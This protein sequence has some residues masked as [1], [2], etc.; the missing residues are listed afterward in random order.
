MEIA[1][2]FIVYVSNMYGKRFYSAEEALGEDKELLEESSDSIESTTDDESVSQSEIDSDVETD[3]CGRKNKSTSCIRV[4]AKRKYPVGGSKGKSCRTRGGR[5]QSLMVNSAVPRF[6]SPCLSPIDSTSNISTEVD[7]ST[8]A[9]SA[10]V[11]SLSPTPALGERG[12][13]SSSLMVDDISSP[14]N[15]LSSNSQNIPDP[16]QKAP[17]SF[18]H[19][20]HSNVKTRNYGKVMGTQYNWSSDAPTIHNFPFTEKPGLKVEV[21]TNLIDFLKL[22]L[23]DELFFEIQESTNEYADRVINTSRPLRRRSVLNTWKPLTADEL[24]KFF[25][26]VLHMGL[27]AMP[28]YKHYWRKDIYFVNQIFPSVMSRERFEGITRFLHFGDRPIAPDDRLGK[29]R[30]LT[31]HLNQVMSEIYTPEKN[32]VFGRE[33]DALAWAFTLSPIHKK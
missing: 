1:S 23:T 11:L 6:A 7:S 18:V 12:L 21:S 25:G 8:S 33:Y 28:S 14:T 31:N 30:L 3:F 16:S 32:L 19:Q 22:L 15:K 4:S 5:H 9:T 2:K 20:M 27:I 26:L 17:L 29:V 10:S 13:I 24:R